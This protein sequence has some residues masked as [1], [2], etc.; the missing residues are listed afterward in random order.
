M[1][2]LRTIGKYLVERVLGQGAMGT[3]YLARDPGLER[4]VAVK[5]MTVGPADPPDLRLR[6]RREAEAAGGLRHPNIV[7]IYDVGEDD[8]RPYI[9]MEY[10]EGADLAQVLQDGEARSTE[11]TLDVL[12]QVCEG[13][14][15]AHRNGV[16]HRDVKPANI[17]IGPGGQVKIMDF[18]LA[19]L[20][21]STVT[22]SGRLLGTVQYMAPEQV[23]GGRVDHR[24]DVFA[25]GAI[26]Y[27]L[28]ARRKPFEGDSLTA[29][30]FQIIH[31]APDAAALAVT[32][33]SPGLDGIILKALARDPDARYPSLE[34]L[35]ADLGDLVREAARPLHGRPEG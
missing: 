18:G 10:V 4:L 19:R 6:F 12:R 23:Q 17:R 11:W 27:E 2:V 20:A 16:V 8:G 32:A 31:G 35:H 29:I 30:M 25:V 22:K 9:A 15:Y 1:P 7:T 3:V 28:V 26:A 21:S 33:Y 13:L 24:A 14:A 34:A 5:T